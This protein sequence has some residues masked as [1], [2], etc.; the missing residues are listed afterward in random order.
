MFEKG[1]VSQCLEL[2]GLQEFVFQ[3]EDFGFDW[4]QDILCLDE[5]D[6][7]K[8]ICDE[9]IKIRYKIV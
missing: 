9:E 4:F 3:L 1:I 8:L 5:D 7:V 6:F 2:F